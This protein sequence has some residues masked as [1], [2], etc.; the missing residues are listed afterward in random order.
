MK[1]FDMVSKG[2]ALA[3]FASMATPT[4]AQ[5]NC[6]ASGPLHTT[7]GGSLATICSVLI[8]NCATAGGNDC[9]IPGN[10]PPDATWGCGAVNP[11]MNT[12][13]TLVSSS[14]CKVGTPEAKAAPGLSSGS[15]YEFQYYC[16]TSGD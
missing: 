12:S 8:S 3:A 14:F 7:Y 6:N 10:T 2:A 13:Y 16:G 5:A 4:I 1:V 15:C 11:N 9:S